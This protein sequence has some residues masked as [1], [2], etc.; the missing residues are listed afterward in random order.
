MAHHAESFIINDKRQRVSTFSRVK[1]SIDKVQIS[2]DLATVN[3]TQQGTTI[4]TSAFPA[5]V[6]SIRWDLAFF[7]DTGTSIC[8]I[9]WAI[10]LIKD[11]ESA[12][13]MVKADGLAF[14][15]PKQNCLVYGVDVIVNGLTFGMSKHTS[16]TTKTMR[17]M[18][19]E[20]EIIF[21]ARGIAVDSFRVFSVIQLFQKL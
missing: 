18:I 21:I 16:G 17:K 5:T 19:I 8:E 9:N 1:R 20:D 12:D 6:T 7:Q 2:V 15:Q 11:G 13:T 10:V 4:L 14:Y 3:G